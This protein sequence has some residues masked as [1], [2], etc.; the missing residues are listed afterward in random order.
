M[1]VCVLDKQDYDYTLAEGFLFWGRGGSHE[2][3]TDRISRIHLHQAPTPEDAG[4]TIRTRFPFSY[5]LSFH[6]RDDSIHCIR[7]S[8][9]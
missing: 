4:A 8:L 6:T 1:C 2:K 9:F 5:Y 7:Q 3:P